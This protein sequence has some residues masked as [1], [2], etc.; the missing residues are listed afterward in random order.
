MAGPARR[1][2]PAGIR[3]DTPMPS[4]IEDYALIGDCQT[5]ALVARDG[6]IDWLCLPRFDSGACF[7]ALL[8]TPEHGRWLI[9]PPATVRAIRRRYR[10][11]TLVLETEFETD[12]G[13]RRRHRLHAA[14]RAQRPTLVRIV[15]GRRGRVPMRMEL[16]V[17]FDYGSIVPWVRRVERRHL[18]DRRPGQLACT[19]DVAAA[20]RGLHDGGRVHRRRG[21]AR[22]VRADLASRRT[23]A[24]APASTPPRPLARDR[25]LV[26]RVVERAAPTRASDHEAGRPLADHAQ[27]ADLRADRRHRR[28]ADHLAARAARRRAQLGLPLLLAAR[29]HLH[30]LAL[31]HAGYHDEAQ[32]WR[33]WLL[34]AVAGEPAKTQIMYGLAGERRLTEL[35]LPWLP[36]YEGSRPVRVGNAASQPV[37]ARR[38]RRGA[39]RPVPGRARRA[40]TPMDDGWRVGQA[41]LD[42]LETAWEQPDEGIWEVRGPAAA[43]HPLEGD[44]LGGLRPGRQGGRATSAS[45][46]RS[47]A[48][49][50][51]A[52]P[53]HAQVCREGFDAELER[54]R[55][56][57]RLASELDASLLMIPLVGFLPADD[58]RV[59]GTVEAIE[60]D[61]LH[62]GFVASLH[63]DAGAWTACRRARGRSCP[64]PSGWP[65]TSPAGPPRRRPT[66]LRA[67]AGDLRNDVGLLSEEYDPQA[68]PAAGQLPAG[69]LARRPG[70]HGA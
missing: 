48:G 50:A 70:Q 37:P 36:G 10:P 46:A 69:V 7:A 1:G 6:S 30:A 8:G 15:E 61:L 11:D 14:A 54:V 43:L 41:L 29:R 34:R 47:S 18:G 59:R 49:A 53:I 64:A 60:R 42:F 16:V 35:E 51:F 62:D 44:G 12:D 38:L 2:P 17:R 55:A 27:G 39:R 65:T 45:R 52:T 19:R 31:L 9:A 4:H 32:A 68:A 24:A 13:R 40:W 23:R 20:R 66:H 5:A 26:A 21:R 63:A 33:E 56:V 28:R 57:L 3:E 67:A 58:P 25:A 22:A